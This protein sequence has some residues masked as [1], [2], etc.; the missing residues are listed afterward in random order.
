MK[1][2]WQIIRIKM[3]KNKW[4]I[5]KK[6]YIRIDN[7]EKHIRLLLSSLKRK[8]ARYAKEMINDNLFTND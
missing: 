6:L 3:G 5:K 7:E 4:N 2:D 8:F 1:I